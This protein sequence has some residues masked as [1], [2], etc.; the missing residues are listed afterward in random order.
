MIELTAPAMSFFELLWSDYQVGLLERGESPLRSKILYL[1]RLLLNPSLQL[2]FL[3]RLAQKGPRPLQLLIRYV[4]VVVFSCE[5]HRF[6][7]DDTIVLGPGVA[8]PH[9]F[10]IIIGGGTQIGSGVTIYNSTNIGGNRHMPRT[11]NVSGDDSACRLGDRSVIYAY[12]AVQ[13]PFDIGHDAV[14]GIHVV[15]DGHVPPGAMRSYKTLRLAGEW[16]GENRTHWR[17]DGGE[18]TLLTRRD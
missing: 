14:V 5:I 10:N 18:P 7:T 2:A 16:P 4:Q 6:Q 12:T 17:R 9:P 11:A 15:V 1:P 13:G 8:F 3:V